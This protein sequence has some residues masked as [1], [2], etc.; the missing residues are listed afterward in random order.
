MLLIDAASSIRYNVIDCM[1]LN[2]LDSA[3]VHVYV[4]ALP[5]WVRSGGWRAESCD[6]QH[7]VRCGGVED[8]IIS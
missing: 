4:F 7:A 3:L 1:V 5:R 6:A 2:I 8:L